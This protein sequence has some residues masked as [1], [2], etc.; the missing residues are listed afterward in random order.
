MASYLHFSLSSRNAY[1]RLALLLGASMIVMVQAGRSIN[2]VSGTYRAI[3]KKHPI[4]RDKMVLKATD[5]V[6][7]ERFFSLEMGSCKI[8]NW[9]F[10]TQL[11]EDAFTVDTDQG[12][13]IILRGAAQECLATEIPV[14]IMM[15][16]QETTMLNNVERKPGNCYFDFVIG[17]TSCTYE[18][19]S[20]LS[21]WVWLAPVLVILLLLIVGCAVLTVCCVRRKRRTEA[22]LN[23]ASEQTASYPAG[24]VPPPPASYHPS[25]A[26]VGPPSTPAYP[27]Q[28]P[29]S[30]V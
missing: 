8:D 14:S 5:N 7:P 3:D 26:P 16:P 28:V 10:I 22:E 29:A 27:T 17:N 15:C 9:R 4:C 12:A 20:G 19:S 23:S 30:T 2:R 24:P 25:Q 6:G 21:I 13:G 11:P 18:M 1:L